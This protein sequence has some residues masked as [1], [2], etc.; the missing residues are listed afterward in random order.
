MLT[1]EDLDLQLRAGFALIHQVLEAAPGAFQLL[2]GGVVHHLVQLQRNQVID[3]RDARVDHHLGV[4][5]DGHGAIE[6][7]RDEFLDQ[8]LAA[9]LGGR[10]AAEASLSTIWSSSPLS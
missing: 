1:V 8:V 6:H 7:L 2:E 3:L 10:F 4:A 5:G 9:L